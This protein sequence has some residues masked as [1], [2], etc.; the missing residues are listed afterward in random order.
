MMM[1][2]GAIFNNTRFKLGKWTIRT[3]RQ[4]IISSCN[5]L[6][7]KAQS[8]C[9]GERECCLNTHTHPLGP[10]M[11]FLEGNHLVERFGECLIIIW[12]HRVLN[13]HS[14]TN[15]WT[16]TPPPPESA[17]E[18]AIEREREKESMVSPPHSPTVLLPFHLSV[19]AMWFCTSLAHSIS[20]SLKWAAYLLGLKEAD[21][22]INGRVK[23]FNH[24]W[25]DG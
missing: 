4:E 20:M 25:C 8:V 23:Y 15:G 7:D 18:R 2:M 17:G 6:C 10:Q 12:A 9:V 3:T 1:M 19:P 16:P 14:D 5:V 13:Y 21:C 11:A 24:L 22:L